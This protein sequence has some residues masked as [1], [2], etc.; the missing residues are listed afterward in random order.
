[1]FNEKAKLTA[2]AKELINKGATKSQVKSELAKYVRNLPPQRQAMLAI[3]R[4][5]S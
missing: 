4:A 2:F 3:E 5:K 1:M